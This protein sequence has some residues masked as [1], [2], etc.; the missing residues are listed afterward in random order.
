[1][2]AYWLS[3][4]TVVYLLEASQHA[5]GRTLA[6]NAAGQIDAG[7]VIGVSQTGLVADSRKQNAITLGLRHAF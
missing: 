3:K 7:A 2:Q 4:R 1:M 6:A 5:H